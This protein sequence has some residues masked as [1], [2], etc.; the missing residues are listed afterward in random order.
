MLPAATLRA[1]VFR[2]AMLCNFAGLPRSRF[3]GRYSESNTVNA[4]C[5]CNVVA[6]IKG[7]MSFLII[8]NLIC[9]AKRSYISNVVVK[10]DL[11][12]FYL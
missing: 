3:L 11:I 10:N 5:V 9:W 7:Y 2:C 12:T 6:H 8:S 4:V 1:D